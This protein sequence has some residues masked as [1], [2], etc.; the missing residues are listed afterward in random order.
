ME[1]LSAATALKGRHQLTHGCSPS[2][3]S[4]E[5]AASTNDGCSPSAA[6]KGRS[7]PNDGS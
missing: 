5:G 7:H 6:L 1:L 3:T 4:P 2:A